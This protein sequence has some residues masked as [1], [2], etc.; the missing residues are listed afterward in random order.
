MT[1]TLSSAANNCFVCGANN[2]IGL[3]LNFELHNDICVAN[4]TPE[5]NYCGYNGIV[6]GGIIFSAL[7]D[8]MANWLF[9][10]KEKAFTAR[11]SIRYF[12]EL[13]CNTPTELE[14]HFLKR[15]G[16]MTLMRGI[17]KSLHDQQIIA[18][19]EASFMS[20]T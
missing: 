5:K 19:T 2:P 13:L 8:V 3:K 15:K 20:E 7:D 9:L 12:S 1:S 6:H 18:E 11:C 17:M 10:K 14:G 16:R 4:F